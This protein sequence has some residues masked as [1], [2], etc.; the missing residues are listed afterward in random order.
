MKKLL[1]LV[2]ILLTSCNSNKAKYVG[3]DDFKFSENLSHNEFIVKLEE[4]SK[5]N[6]YPNIDY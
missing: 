2:V 3:K 4:Y 1:F 6:P 5:T